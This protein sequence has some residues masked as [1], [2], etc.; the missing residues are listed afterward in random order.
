M[1]NISTHYMVRAVGGNIFL[2]AFLKYFKAPPIDLNVFL[3][4]QTDYEKTH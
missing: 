3:V 1:D 4:R 2:L